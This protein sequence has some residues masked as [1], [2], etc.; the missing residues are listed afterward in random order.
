MHVVCKDLKLVQQVFCLRG[1]ESQAIPRI[2]A[3]E[4]VEMYTPLTRPRIH[5]EGLY[6]PF[7][8][9]GDRGE[10][11]GSGESDRRLEWSDN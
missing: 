3:G 9:S 11:C 2:Q 8:R 10:V 6:G 7:S 4:G 5:A 1:G